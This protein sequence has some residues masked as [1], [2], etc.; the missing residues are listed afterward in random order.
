[1]TTFTKEELIAIS[2]LVVENKNSAKLQKSSNLSYME[3][4]NLGNKIDTM[5]ESMKQAEWLES[6]KRN[7]DIEFDYETQ[8]MVI[9]DNLNDIEYRIDSNLVDDGKIVPY[10]IENAENYADELERIMIPEARSESDR[11]LMREDL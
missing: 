2:I 3:S 7:Y 10:Y 4:I 9:Q 8:E 1:M 6:Q 5:I 11:E